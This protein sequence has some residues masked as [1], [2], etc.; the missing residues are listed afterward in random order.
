MKSLHI[1]PCQTEHQSRPKY[2][3]WLF[4]YM[5]LYNASSFTWNDD[6]RYPNHCTWKSTVFLQNWH[7]IRNLLFLAY[8][9]LHNY[10]FFFFSTSN[11]IFTSLLILWSTFKLQGVWG[12]TR[13]CFLRFC[14]LT[15]SS[16]TRVSIN[17]YWTNGGINVQLKTSRWILCECLV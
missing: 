4:A 5:P 17:I 13:L 1:S 14:I 2:T 12:L 10:Y 16:T 8:L 15:I 3:W 9:K 7:W 6:C 11:A